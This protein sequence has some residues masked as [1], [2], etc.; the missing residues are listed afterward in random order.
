MSDQQRGASPEAIAAHYDVSDVF[1]SLWLDRTLTY[2]C[3]LWADE[4]TLESAQLKK[5]DFHARAIGSPSARRVLDIGC[6]W[7]SMLRRLVDSHDVHEAIGLTLSKG[8]ESWIRRQPDSRIRVRLESWEDHE[9]SEPYDAIVSI[10]A[11]EHFV[12]PSFSS[13]ERIEVYQ[14][15][16]RK[17]RALLRPNGK[18][19]LQTSAYSRGGFVTGAIASIFPESDLP[20]LS[21]LVT[22]AEGV[23][24]VVS[25]RNDRDDYARTC[26]AWGLG[27]RNRREEA[28]SLVGEDTVL[29]FERFLEAAVKGFQLEVFQLLRLTFRRFD[30]A[31]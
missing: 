15:F 18:L 24:E 4:D 13:A 9:A 20:R 19:S 7:G 1:Y 14:R 8:Q 21:E 25:I 16:F 12:R 11:L 26:M 29:R 30:P 5:L 3:G 22:A 28:V 10:G 27:L 31:R 17:C 23:M 2:S 6:G